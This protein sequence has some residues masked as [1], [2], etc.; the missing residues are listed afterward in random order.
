MCE[1][2]GFSAKKE[3]PIERYLREFYQHSKDHPDGWGLALFRE[4][5]SKLYCWIL[6][7]YRAVPWHIS[8]KQ[9]WVESIP[10]TVTRSNGRTTAVSCGR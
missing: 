1:I 2:L 3:Q 9:R 7:A 10:K 8:A 6:S 4:G 5:D